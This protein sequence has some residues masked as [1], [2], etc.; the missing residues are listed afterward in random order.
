MRSC[1][2]WTSQRPRPQNADRDDEEIQRWLED[3]LPAILRTAAERSAHIVSVVP[4]SI[5][6]AR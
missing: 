2:N 3:E 5:G 6:P 4:E 1:L